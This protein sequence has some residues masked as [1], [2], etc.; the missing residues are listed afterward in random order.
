VTKV[1]IKPFYIKASKGKLFALYIF[2]SLGQKPEQAVIYFPPFAEE[3]NKAR[4]MMTLMSYHAALLGYGMLSIDLYGT[5]DSEGDFFDARWEIWLDDMAQ[6]IHW[7]KMQGVKRFVFIGLR[8]GAILAL[9]CIR[10]FADNVERI[11]MWQPIVIG[12]NFMTQFL[13]LHMVADMMQHAKIKTTT[14]LRKRIVQGERI[15]VAGYLLDP[16]L[17]EKIDELDLENL[18]VAGIPNIHWID[19]VPGTGR[20]MSPVNQRIIETW[21]RAGISVTNTVIVG[22]A[23]WSSLEI[24]VVPELIDKTSQ[25]LRGEENG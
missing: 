8:L 14:A 16:I 6:A 20:H 22:E 9:D 15:E 24:S 12:K 17:M 5:G 2:G 3:M 10:L 7:L 23:F 1:S 13:R 11:I 21:R 4:R 18:G 25:I 19:L